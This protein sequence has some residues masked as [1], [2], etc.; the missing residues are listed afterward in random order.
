VGRLTAAPYDAEAELDGFEALVRDGAGLTAAQ[1]RGAAV[2]VERQL[3]ENGTPAHAAEAA[4]EE[5]LSR[6][7]DVEP[8]RTVPA[9][10]FGTEPRID[11]PALWG[12][13]ESPIVVHEGISVLAGEGGVGK[14][15][16]AVNLAICLASGR[17]V[18]RSF[19]GIE[20]PNPAPVLYLTA[21]GNRDVFRARFMAAAEALLGGD[22]DPMLGYPFEQLALFF[23]A[24]G[25][26]LEIP[27]LAALLDE[28][29]PQ[30][31]I[32]DTV[33]L[34]HDGEENSAS[35]WK[36]YVVKPLRA[37]MSA[38][39]T[40][41]LLL[42]HQSKPT[43]GREDR[44]RTRGTSA[45]RDDADAHLILKESKNDPADR[46]LIFDKLRGAPRGDVVL[47]YDAPRAMFEATATEKDPLAGTAL[48]AGENDLPGRR[49]PGGRETAELC[50]LSPP[51]GMGLGVTEPAES[52]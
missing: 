1:I 44:H 7:L 22:F 5:A 36:R 52:C 19:A 30:L 16:L 20:V 26:T 17:P 46:V 15:A 39:R 13:S 18:S 32:L 2:Y 11:E 42:H 3:I 43:E 40:A 27:T 50:R 8:A 24:R 34:F 28:I 33:G 48:A 9:W 14:T 37:L 41:F 47:R 12:T 10:A 51:F 35:D 25:A 6:A 49:E 31:V 29:R 23:A 38:Y 45:I 4:I 21:E